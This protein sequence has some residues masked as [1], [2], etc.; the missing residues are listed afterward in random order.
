MKKVQ[1][2][3][4]PYKM[5]TKLIID[6]FDIGKG[7][8]NISS[9]KKI[10][11]FIN[12]HV[13]LQTWIEPR[14]YDDWK[15]FLNEITDEQRNDTVVVDFSGR[16]IDFEDLQQ[17][18]QSQ[19]IKRVQETR[20][21]LKFELKEE[22]DDRIL[23]QNIDEIVNALESARFKSLVD[24]RASQGLQ[25][26]YLALNK[27]YEL[28]KSQEFRIVFAGIYSSGKSTLLNALIRHDIL[29]TSDD[30]CTSMN[31]KI[32]HD[33][34][35][36]ENET[37]LI[38]YDENKTPL[39]SKKFQRDEDCAALFRRICPDSQEDTAKNSLYSA[40]HQIEIGANLSHLYPDTVSEDKFKLVLIDTPGMDSAR[41]SSN[42]ENFHE[43]IALHEISSPMKPMIALCVD[44]Q[45][46]EDKNIG[47]F[48]QKIVQQSQSD[49]GGF[50]DR[51]LFIM[52]KSDAKSY[53]TKRGESAE[54]SRRKFSEYLT[55]SSK[56]GLTSDEKDQQLK[57][58]AA[59]FIP[60]I[61]MT[62]A[63]NAYV[64]TFLFDK[65]SND[66]ETYNLKSNFNAFQDKICKR[67]FNNYLLARHC[68]TSQRCKDQIEKD[69]EDALKGKNVNK[70][71]W[72]QTGVPSLEDAIKD[73]IALYAYPILV[74]ELL[75]TFELLLKDVQ[76]FTEKTRKKYQET[77][78]HLGET[79]G[80]GKE[81][82]NQKQQKEEQLAHLDKAK[83]VCDNQQHALESIVFDEN[84]IKSSIAEFHADLDADEDISKIRDCIINHGGKMDTGTK[85][86][87]TV[88]SEIDEMVA[89]IKEACTKALEKINHA[90]QYASSDYEA[91]LKQIIDV[92]K[93]VLLELEN[94]NI[95]EDSGYDFRDSFIWNEAD[96][97]DLNNLSDEVK[98]AKSKKKEP[99][100]LE[101]NRKKR[102]YSQSRNPF[103]KIIALFMKD[104]VPKTEPISGHYDVTE[105][106]HLITTWE[107]NIECE[108]IA[109]QDQA[110]ENVA[111][112]KD[113]IS[114]VLCK[115]LK[116]FGSYQKYIQKKEQELASISNN[117]DALKMQLDKYEKDC[118]WLNALSKKMKGE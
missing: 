25:E 89:R 70:A 20:I 35:L 85:S 66:E 3:Y 92:V 7:Q 8:S 60:R 11:S 63:I 14:E 55:D 46:Y 32:Y 21:T 22:L 48:M 83:Q 75:A 61:F 33:R 118:D 104:T 5:I 51:F 10:K 57:Q 69:F 24:E 76:G 114:N 116:E 17:S 50:T 19:N 109:M 41:S 36:K 53:Q 27:N 112:V 82:V 81:V 67:Q 96:A 91:Q 23:A 94:G 64:A 99:V 12:N 37:T 71:T 80:S 6:D 42:G 43:E 102:E 4:N 31:C 47:E 13:P 108:S 15:G 9:Y 28:A 1:L 103:K 40:A 107:G 78:D 16:K 29:P 73:Y 30:T 117:I 49:K 74:R 79:E 110:Q 88:D 77:F 38:V 100:L 62:S 101:K 106:N 45:K 84:S 65:D 93:N 113:Y 72:L 97:L 95:L 90:L 52:N 98:K 39:A 68:D 87:C 86:S 34:S 54:S 26:K 111:S 115:L 56:W 18:L 2:Y 105:I 44:S 58:S 59:G